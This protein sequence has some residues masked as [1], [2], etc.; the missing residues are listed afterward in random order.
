[1]W[2]DFLPQNPLRVVR[3]RRQRLQLILDGDYPYSR[4]RDDKWVKMGWRFYAALAETVHPADVGELAC[5]FP[6]FYF[7]YELQTS[8]DEAIELLRWELEAYLLTEWSYELISRRTGCSVKTIEIYHQ[9]YY[10]VRERLLTKGYVN[11]MVIGPSLQRG[12]SPNEPDVLWKMYAYYCGGH[13]VGAI[14]DKFTNPAIA[15][16]PEDIPAVIED[17]ALGNLKRNAMI[18]THTMPINSFTQMAIIDAWMK[19]REIDAAS[20]AAQQ[21]QATILANLEACFKAMPF[22]VGKQPAD[23]IQQREALEEYSRMSA[24][25][26]TD[27]LMALSAGEPLRLKPLLENMEYPPTSTV[28]VKEDASDE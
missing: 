26:R 24:E 14:I 17:A 1:M 8:Q 27:E 4:R 9:I 12:L 3:W 22:S 7:A 16:R 5:R 19:L 28:T 21:G 25:L 13:V 23:M 6:D 15:E 2:Q 10:D 18:A 20:E 11:H